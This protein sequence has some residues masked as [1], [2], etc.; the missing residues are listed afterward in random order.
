MSQSI[1]DRRLGLSPNLQVDTGLFFDMA[2]CGV[3]Y[4][5]IRKLI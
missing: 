5:A 1:A 2:M 4:A 3:V